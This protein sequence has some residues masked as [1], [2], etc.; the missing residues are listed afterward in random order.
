MTAA[1]HVRR[2]IVIITDGYSSGGT[3][4]FICTLINNWPAKDEFV[5]VCNHDHPA[6]DDIFRKR[7]NRKVKIIPH[8][9]LTSVQLSKWC[10]RHN[11]GRPLRALLRNSR[12]I[13][14]ICELVLLS[15][16]LKAQEPDHLIISS[17]GYPNGNI[18]RM[19]A[20]TGL[21]APRWGM[22]VF[23]YHNGVDPLPKF[24]LER[25][26]ENLYDMLLEKGCSS[27]VTVSKDT[28]RKM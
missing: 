3:D 26:A 25:W 20:I 22:P 16:I 12:Y 6:I 24:F 8:F 19:A 7:L 11:I 18:C 10:D 27:I 14:D 21:L 15:R 4:V 13:I 2:K 23:V 28:Q 9:L 5:I 1:R 17:G